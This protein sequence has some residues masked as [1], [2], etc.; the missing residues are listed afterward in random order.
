MNAVRGH[1]RRGRIEL[2][3]TQRRG[4]F[5]VGNEAEVRVRGPVQD[6][7]PVTC[8]IPG[9]HQPGAEV[10]VEELRSTAAPLE[11][12]FRGR[13]GYEARFAYS[14]DDRPS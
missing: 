6:Q 10:H 9:H 7:E 4:W 12:E 11:Y 1:V 13:C 14:A 2:D 8:V 5:R 3:H